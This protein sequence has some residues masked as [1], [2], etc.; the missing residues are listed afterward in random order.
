MKKIIALAL[1]AVLVCAV[2]GGCAGQPQKETEPVTSYVAKTE[3]NTGA[4][5]LG[6]Y[7]SRFVEGDNPLYGTWQME[8]FDYLSFIFRNDELAEMVMGNEGDFSSLKIDEKK[9]T[10]SVQFVLGLSGKYSYEL[11]EDFNTLTLAQD[12]SKIVLQRQED[13]S[14]IP[15]APKKPAVDG[16][17]V[18][19]WQNSDKMTYFFGLDG[20]MYANKVSLE[21]VYT[22]SAENGKIKAAYNYGGKVK[23]E[24]SYELKDDKLVID[25]EKYSKFSGL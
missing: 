17:I 22:Y 9:K 8:G 21:T 19:W 20:I 15:E 1:A 11:S 3:K 18:G 23:E 25:G 2:F 6:K 7:F 4:V 13:F 16:E 10:L 24:H 12:G 5:V 14:L